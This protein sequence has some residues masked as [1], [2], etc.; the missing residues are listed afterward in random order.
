VKALVTG[1]AGLIGS[2]LVDLLLE[3]GYEVRVLDS[4][5]PHAHP[6]GRPDWVPEDV[7]F[8]HGRVEDRAALERSMK[9]V[10]LIFHQA[11]HGGFT[12][13]IARYFEVN[14]L[15]ACHMLEIARDESLPVEK[16]VFASTQ[17]VY[18][19]GKYRCPSH[20]TV[21]PGPRPA[22]RLEEGL[23]D[24]V[25]PRCGAPVEPLATD[26]SRVEPRTPYALSKMASER[27]FLELGR[28]YGVRVT[29]LRYALTYGPRQSLHNPYTGICSI[30]S[31]RILNGLPPIVFEDGNQVRDFVYVEDV[32]KANL[33]VALDPR[34]DYGVFN[35]G[36]GRPT[37]VL[38]FIDLLARALGVPGVEP[39]V[40]GEYRPGEV[41]HLFTDSSMLSSLG[42]KPEVSLSEGLRKYVEWVRE[43]DEV[44]E[45]FTRAVGELRAAGVI[46]RVAPGGGGR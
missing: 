41:R 9:G 35:V 43:Q 8:V 38:E 7:E 12:P 2:H 45:T 21:Y 16:I 17:A 40:T 34:A 31:T 39:R 44:P 18:G 24:P 28:R 29:G 26:E 27:V 23:W 3:N 33:K 37:S 22:R 46:R 10:G 32:A 19:E 42:W 11:A 25:C 30:F 14:V 13:E 6:R 15:S 36:T 20:G 4:L 5:E 1:G